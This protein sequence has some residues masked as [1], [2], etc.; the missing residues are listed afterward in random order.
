MSKLHHRHRS[1]RSSHRHGISGNSRLLP[2]LQHPQRN[3]LQQVDHVH[4]RVRE[5]GVFDG[6]HLV[7]VLQYHRVQRSSQENS[8]SE[9]TGR[10]SRRGPAVFEQ[11]AGR[12]AR[13][14]KRR[15]PVFVLDGARLRMGHDE[16]LDDRRPRAA[17]CGD[18]KRRSAQAILLA[19]RPRVQLDHSVQ[20]GEGGVESDATVQQ[21]RAVEAIALGDGLGDR[22]K[23]AGVGKGSGFEFGPLS[24]FDEAE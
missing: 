2:L 5:E 7:D 8:N 9:H 22:S 15:H 3:P 19:Q 13:E 20:D 12:V 11:L 10:S 18:V 4:R 24:R 21:R 14:V 16:A 6:V 1:V 23:V 17:P